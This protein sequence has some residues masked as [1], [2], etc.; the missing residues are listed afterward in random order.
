[1]WKREEKEK[2]AGWFLYICFSEAHMHS[3]HERGF[4]H[5]EAGVDFILLRQQVLALHPDGK[6]VGG[7]V[8]AAH[9]PQHEV[10]RL[11]MVAHGSVESFYILDAR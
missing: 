7:T 2:M 5:R 8:G 4:R 10:F 3:A 11:R 1:M 9:V 6:P